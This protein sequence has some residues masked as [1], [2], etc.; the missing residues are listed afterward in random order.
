MAIG[1]AHVGV[2]Q[3]VKLALAVDRTHFDDAFARLDPIRAGIHAQRPADAARNAVVEVETPD[4][5]LERGCR[6]ALVRRRRADAQPR[7]ADALGLA[8]P[9]GRKPHHEATDTALAH[10]KV[11]A[12]PD[13]H[14]RDVGGHG[15]QEGGKV[16]LV[17]RLEQRVGH[18][19]CAEPGDLVHRGIRGQPAA[20]R[21]ERLP[22][23]LQQV[24]ALAH[25]AAALPASSS[26]SA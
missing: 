4:A 11:R 1:I 18:P 3:D 17:R 12:D 13:R 15:L 14:H 22:K 20:D 24:A 19:A 2:R 8:E 23:P 16:F 10:Q 21:G 9:L 26:G 25:S 7:V 6:H 5:A